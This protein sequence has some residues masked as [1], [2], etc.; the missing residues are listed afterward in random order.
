M[1]KSSNTSSVA[2]H[3]LTQFNFVVYKD[4]TGATLSL[5]SSYTDEFTYQIDD[6]SSTPSTYSIDIFESSD[7]YCDFVYSLSYDSTTD[8][9]PTAWTDNSFGL[10]AT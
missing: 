1:V 5:K 9:L 6:S 4:C 10:G 7:P 8:N 3:S 2:T